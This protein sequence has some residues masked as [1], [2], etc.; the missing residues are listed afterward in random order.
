MDTFKIIR[1]LPDKRKYHRASSF[2]DYRGTLKARYEG[3]NQCLDKIE[4]KALKVDV[5]KIL[6]L[7]WD[8]HLTEGWK[9]MSS[10]EKFKMAKDKENTEAYRLAQ[11]IAKAIE[12]GE[13]F[14]G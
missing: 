9:R 2:V 3:F 12:S 14:D 7:V 10:W 4:A 6:E 5:D 13:V 11:E 1:E 8:S